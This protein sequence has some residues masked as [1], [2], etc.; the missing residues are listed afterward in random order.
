MK[1][2]LT[3]VVG[4]L[5]HEMIH[6]V[7][8]LTDHGGHQRPIIVSRAEISR[9]TQRAH[10]LRTNHALARVRGLAAESLA[11]HIELDDLE[12]EQ[13]DEAFVASSDG[14]IAAQRFLKVAESQSP[15]VGSTRSRF[16]IFWRARPSSRC[17]SVSSLLASPASGDALGA[18]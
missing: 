15:V 14:E 18:S 1:P 11:I 4:N 5:V 8:R 2:E 6:V 12:H 17:N 3:H 13:R 9:A 16:A 10:D 7:R